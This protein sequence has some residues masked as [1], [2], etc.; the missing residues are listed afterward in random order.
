ME[1]ENFALSDEEIRQMDEITEEIEVDKPN[2]KKPP[3]HRRY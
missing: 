2:P 3:F 1:L